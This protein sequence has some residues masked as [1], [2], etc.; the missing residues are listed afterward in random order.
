LTAP[1]E[2]Y[3]SAF[4]CNSAWTKSIGVV[5]GAGAWKGI[6]KTIEP[7]ALAAPRL[8]LWLTLP[9]GSDVWAASKD[10]AAAD[11]RERNQLP[12]EATR[13][14]TSKKWAKQK[15]VGKVGKKVCTYWHNGGGC[16]EPSRKV[17]DN[18][19]KCSACTQIRWQALAL[20]G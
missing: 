20:E 10:A 15:R 14:G 18:P 9:I 19:A 4:C 1:P 2:G 3:I 11:P 8:A 13:E 17:S 12:E 7:G 16:R 6:T 5:A